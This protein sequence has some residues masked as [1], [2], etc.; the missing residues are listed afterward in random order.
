MHNFRSI[1][2]ASAVL[3]VAVS[4]SAQLSWKQISTTA[5]PQAASEGGFATDTKRNRV[6][7]FGGLIKPG[8]FSNETWSWNGASWK[9]LSTTTAPIARFA[10][11][12]VY[13]SARDRMVM[14]GGAGG[15]L[16]FFNNETWEFDGTNWKKMAPKTSPGRRVFMVMAYDANRKRTVLFGGADSNF[17]DVNDT[18]EWDGTNWTQVRTTRAPSPRGSGAIAYDPSTKSVLMFGGSSRTSY[19]D[20]WSYDGKNWTKLT[21]SVKPA[22]RWGA[23]MAFDEVRGRMVLAGSGG[24]ASTDTW[25]WDGRQWLRRVALNAMDKADPQ[26]TFDPVRKRLLYYGG[27]G[28]TFEFVTGAAAVVQSYGAGCRGSNGVPTL[29]AAPYSMPLIG[30]LF[31]LGLSNLPKST[32]PAWL[33]VG[34]KKSNL[35]LRGFGMPGCFWLQ[36]EDAVFFVGNNTGSTIAK[37]LLPNQTSLL[38]ARA[39]FQGV[40]ADRTANLLGATTSN[41]LE[42]KVGM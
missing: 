6:I 14:F 39:F 18:W 10:C 4:V 28:K 41:G 5:R 26:S 8:F 37:F 23:A 35:D 2:L 21:T 9:K 29:A 15:S 30:G 22:A 16:G 32:G 40:A 1:S 12:M 25:E 24:G 34:V 42:V 20:T 11:D 31:V 19:D 13:D 7:M 3:T 38:G 33:S 36:S 17:N 27:T